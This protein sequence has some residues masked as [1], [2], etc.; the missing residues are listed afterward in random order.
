MKPS[1]ERDYY[2]RASD[3]DKRGKLNP[4][5]VLDLF[6]DVAGC[7]ADE[8]GIGSEAM[9]R[10]GLLWVVVKIKFRVLADPE[11]HQLVTVKTWPLPQ[12]RVSFRREYRIEGENGEAFVIGCS[13][14]A[15]MTVSE[16]KLALVQDVYPLER[17]ITE[18][19]FE[20][21]LGRIKDFEARGG[22]YTVCPGFSELD[23][24][25]HVNNARYASFVMDALAPADS[26]VI[27]SFQI[28]Y[29]R[30][31]MAGEKLSLFTCRREGELLAKGVNEGGETMFS[32]RIELRQSREDQ[33][34]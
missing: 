26:E 15:F 24:N 19:S 10:R 5:S 3:F 29:H 25:G 20:G 30:E 27:D 23:M 31:V 1:F 7:H 4:A 13:D 22:A 2:L 11:M 21:R 6:Q 34:A 33:K 17:F 12:K 9:I 32:C 16:R 14:W 8:L 28:D 18:Q